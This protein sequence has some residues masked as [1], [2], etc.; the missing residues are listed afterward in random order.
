MLLILETVVRYPVVPMCLHGFYLLPDFMEEVEVGLWD[1]AGGVGTLDYIKEVITGI[2][3]IVDAIEVAT[4][5]FCLEWRF[6][7][8]RFVY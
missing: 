6:D 5:M 2:V 3:G 8:W 1:Q 4:K 7:L